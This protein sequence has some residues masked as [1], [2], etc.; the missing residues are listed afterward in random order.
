[1][2]LFFL[3]FFPA[4]ISQLINLSNTHFDKTLWV[5]IFPSVKRE[6]FTDSPRWH[7]LALT[8]CDSMLCP[9]FGA[10]TAYKC[11]TSMSALPLLCQVSIVPAKAKKFNFFS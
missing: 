8:F 3:S 7:H 6:H 9:H 11:R 10:C 1:M 4:L 2:Y 5:L